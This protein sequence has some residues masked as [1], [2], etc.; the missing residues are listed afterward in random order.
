MSIFRQQGFQT[1]YFLGAEDDIKCCLCR[2]IF[3]MLLVLRWALDKVTSWNDLQITRS[4][5]PCCS[6][7][8]GIRQNCL[9]DVM[10]KFILEEHFLLLRQCS[11][12]LKIIVSRYRKFHA[13]TARS[14]KA[15]MENY[16]INPKCIS[17]RGFS[18]LAF[19]THK[20]K[21]TDRRV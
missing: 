15:W 5:T 7:K 4:L 1:A 21:W 20:A 14:I 11:L 9:C 16:Q 19:S 2:Q 3:N 6:S 8:T 18:A 13:K 12:N 10:S 17:P